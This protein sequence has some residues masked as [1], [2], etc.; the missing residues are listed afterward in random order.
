M[1]NVAALSLI[2]RTCFF[3]PLA[4]FFFLPPIF[5]INLLPA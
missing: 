3:K 5:A 4:D 2:F 1:D